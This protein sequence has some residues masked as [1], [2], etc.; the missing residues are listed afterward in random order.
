[1]HRWRCDS[2]FRLVDACVLSLLNFSFIS[3]FQSCE[4]VCVCLSED[5]LKVFFVILAVCSPLG[6]ELVLQRVVEVLLTKLTKEGNRID[7]VPNVVFV[8]M[9]VMACSQCSIITTL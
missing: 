7:N 6:A 3:D 1:M 4:H 2:Q 9:H 8:P 5:I